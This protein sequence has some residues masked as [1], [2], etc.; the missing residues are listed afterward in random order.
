M[1]EL[2]DAVRRS[3]ATLGRW[4]KQDEASE[5]SNEILVDLQR[6]L[7]SDPPLAWTSDPPTVPGDYLYA[8][9][10]NPDDDWTQGRMYFND[11]PP[12]PD[13]SDTRWLGP[14]PELPGPCPAPAAGPEQGA[15]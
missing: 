4:E 3:I 2:R 15:S 9:R 7:A 13:T 14:I 1:D 8:Y 11:I 5:E 6:A 12:T 10:F